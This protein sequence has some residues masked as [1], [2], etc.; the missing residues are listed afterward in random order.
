VIE[1]E[2]SKEAPAPDF[3]CPQ[4]GLLIKVSGQ[5]PEACPVCGAK[6]PVAP[7]GKKGKPAIKAPILL[8]QALFKSPRAKESWAPREFF[9][10]V[11]LAFFIVMMINYLVL[12]ANPDGGSGTVPFDPA[13]Y[14]LLNITSVMI[15]IVP[16]LYILLNKMNVAK[17]GLKRI[18]GR[19]WRDTLLLGVLCGFGLYLLQLASSAINIAIFNAT[20][21]EIFGTSQ[22]ETDYLSFINANMGNRLLMLVPIA[23][24]QILAELFYSGTVLN[25]FLQRFQKKMP[26][27]GPASIKLRA[28][29]L[30]SLLSTLFDFGLY[31]NPTAIIA[32][33]LI[34]AVV[35]LLFIYTGNVQSTLIAQ[36]TAILVVIFLA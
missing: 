27:L 17:L 6:L 9:N 35:G 16:V 11:L 26:P 13:F 15:G 14:V 34:H 24:S 28:W 31:F 20:G 5:P 1:L 10:V 29:I 36:A 18:N 23:I 21:L 32:N 3:R 30:S 4:C 8:E 22:A 12:S 33:L 25:G 19:Q 2:R 7:A